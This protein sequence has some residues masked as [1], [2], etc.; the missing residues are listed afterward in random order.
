MTRMQTALAGAMAG[1]CLLAACSAAQP[2]KSGTRSSFQEDLKA[3]RFQ[4]G[5]GL[6]GI[7]G[8]PGDPDPEWPDRLGADPTGVRHLLGATPGLTKDHLAVQHDE[9]RT[10]LVLG[11]R[12]DETASAAHAAALPGALD[13]D[14]PDLGASLDAL[15][16]GQAALASKGGFR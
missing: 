6:G 14:A 2:V 1:L 8:F 11:E 13:L 5:G 15:F 9:T 4:Q 12:W 3:C 16:A 7:P 10:R